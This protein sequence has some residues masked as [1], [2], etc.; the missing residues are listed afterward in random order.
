VPDVN[1]SPNLYSPSL[2]TFFSSR[3]LK[4]VNGRE[5]KTTLIY[6]GEICEVIFSYFMMSS[7][8]GDTSIYLVWPVG[9]VHALSS[10]PNHLEGIDYFLPP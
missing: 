10:K 6:N 1:I 4:L 8:H 5:K 9:I 7:H 2:H 3:V